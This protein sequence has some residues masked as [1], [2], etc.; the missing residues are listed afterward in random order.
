MYAKGE[1][2]PV[3]DDEQDVTV[4]SGQQNETHTEIVFLKRLRDCSK[5]GQDFPIGVRIQN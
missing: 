4:E 3:L 2:V 1:E 5:D